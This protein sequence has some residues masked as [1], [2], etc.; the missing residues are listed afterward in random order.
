VKNYGIIKINET[1][2]TEK[3]NFIEEK[4]NGI[5]LIYDFK[6]NCIGVSDNRFDALE[7]AVIY[8]TTKKVELNKL[9][10]NIKK[11]MEKYDGIK[12]I[13]S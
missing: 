11:E 1:D 5:W 3:I 13:I 4:K 10:A 7:N 2:K 9:I 8:L 12:K 6:G